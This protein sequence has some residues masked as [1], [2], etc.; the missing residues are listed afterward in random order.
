MDKKKILFIV[1]NMESGG[2]SKSMSSLLNV[3]DTEK[4]DVDIFITNPTGVFMELIPESI[5]IIKDERTQFL[6]SSFPKNLAL[7]LK[8]GFVFSFFLR[9]ITA[10]LMLINKGYGA[11]LL[12]RRIFKINKEYDLAVDYNGQHQLYYL[13]DFIK[14][15]KKVSFFHSDYSQWDYYYNMDKKYFQKIDVI[16]TISDTCVT[17]LKKYFPKNQHKIKLF[18]N[19][20]STKLIEKLAN[21]FIVNLMPNSILSVGHLSVAK[22]TPL[23]LEVAK[24]LKT[25]GIAF[26]WYFIGGDTKDKDYLK[27]IENY[28]IQDNIKFLGILVN[29]YPYIKNAEIIAHLSQFEGKSIALDE[30][31]IIE[32]PIVVTNFSTVSDQF[33]H[34][35]NATICNFDSEEIANAIQEL[36]NNKEL[37][38]KYS[39]NLNKEKVDNSDEIKKLYNLMQ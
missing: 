22:G 37:I 12:S 9:I 25:K 24:I 35:V 38:N 7:L 14:A 16:F 31:K 13:I 11:W 28:E 34:H 20:S 2:V 8:K 36:L 5:S 4:Y 6:L 30:A 19:I 10:I 15:K 39:S 32:K 27:L 29:P 26:T 1:S 18:E 3:I 17:A 23:A 21:E 33:Q